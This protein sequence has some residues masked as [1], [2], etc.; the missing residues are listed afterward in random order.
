MKIVLLVLSF[1]FS[2][3]SAGQVKI[4]NE[5]LSDSTVDYFYIGVDNKVSISGIPAD[6]QKFSVMAT[7]A[8]QMRIATGGYIIRVNSVTDSCRLI[9]SAD[10]KIIATRIYKVRILPPPIAVIGTLNTRDTVTVEE[11]LADTRLKVELPGC[12]F[13]H[14]M[15]VTDYMF[16][17][18][19]AK[20]MEDIYQKPSHGHQLSSWERDQILNCKPGAQIVVD[21]IILNNRKTGNYSLPPIILTIKE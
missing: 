19:K 12:Y 15:Q 8:T 3:L 14:D 7:G 11:L 1:S 20:V 2:L 17:I 6:G 13:K 21:K 5:S 9:I 18:S 16:V 4:V 10:G